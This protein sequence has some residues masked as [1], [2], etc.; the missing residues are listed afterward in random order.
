MSSKKR[1]IQP[2]DPD[3]GDKMK[4]IPDPEPELEISFKRVPVIESSGKIIPVCEPTLGGNELKYVTQCIQSNWISSAG[5]FILEFEREF[6]K[7]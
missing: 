3:L 4:L 5:R 1:L 2:E 7:V 6:A